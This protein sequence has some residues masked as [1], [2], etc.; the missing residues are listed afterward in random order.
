[1]E[2]YKV[3]VISVCVIA[4]VV[5]LFYKIMAFFFGDFSELFHEIK[6][7]IK[8]TKVEWSDVL[9]VEFRYYQKLSP[10]AK[11]E[12]L[13]RVKYF[14]HS[15]NFIPK[16]GAII[17][18][19]MK[20]LI[21]ASAAQLTFGLPRLRLPYFKDILI[22][23]S[24]Y[25]NRRTGKQEMGDIITE[26]RIKFS[27]EHIE[28]SLDDPFDGYNLLLHELAN[29]LRLEDYYVND[30]RNF[31]GKEHLNDLDLHFTAMQESLKN[32]S[33]TFLDKNA[34]E[35]KEEFFAV[36]VESFFERPLEFKSELPELYMC[37]VALLNQ[38]P[39]SLEENV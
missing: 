32:R 10:E 24:A 16:E 39:I 31:L 21:S 2:D 29:A 19:R 34:A 26:G 9:K 30:E 33:I 27:L 4:C 23:P 13:S 1:M 14:Y 5:F 7:R 3:F 17:K 20:I 11:K 18:D 8:P 37:L 12:F 38:D 6:T 36:S 25:L 28:K 35:N 15:K 22:Y